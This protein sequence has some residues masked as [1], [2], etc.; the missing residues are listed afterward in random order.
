MGV[1]MKQ[2]IFSKLNQVFKT[3]V[4]R[5]KLCVGIVC[6]CELILILFDVFYYDVSQ[7]KGVMSNGSRLALV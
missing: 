3:L 6:I 1:I 2:N 7:I 5:M 4:R